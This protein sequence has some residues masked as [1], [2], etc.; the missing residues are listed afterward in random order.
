MA[1]KNHYIPLTISVIMINMLNATDAGFPLKDPKNDVLINL[2]DRAPTAYCL[3]HI[4][5]GK[6]FV[7]KEIEPVL[8]EDSTK[9]K[10]Q[11]ISSANWFKE[12]LPTLKLVIKS[13]GTAPEPPKNH[14][15]G[16]NL[17]ESDLI[18]PMMKDEMFETLQFVKP[19]NSIFEPAYTVV[20]GNDPKYGDSSNGYGIIVDCYMSND[21]PKVKRQVRYLFCT[22]ES[23]Y[24]KIRNHRM[25][26][27]GDAG[28]PVL[29]ENDRSGLNL[30]DFA[31]GGD[32]F[33]IAPLSTYGDG[34]MEV[35][36]ESDC[37]LK[38][39]SSTFILTVEAILVMLVFV[40][41][42]I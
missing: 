29:W 1:I 32:R 34:Y 20:T 38:I 17:K 42:M 12:N 6:R 13:L 40:A 33:F 31:E 9:H 39:Q 22:P 5:K 2:E 23:K 8:D 21:I 26:N 16:K 41:N 3:I 19:D 14:V 4:E 30:E 15:I 25:V 36:S 10:Y 24:F 11:P 28:K 18:K 7:S 35:E 37:L 27:D